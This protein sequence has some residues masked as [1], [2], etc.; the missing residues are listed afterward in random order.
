M[1]KDDGLKMALEGLLHATVVHL[2]GGTVF[3]RPLFGA[4]SFKVLER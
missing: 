2:K 4:M 1:L 3:L